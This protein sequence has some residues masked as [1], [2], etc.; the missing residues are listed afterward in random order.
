MIKFSAFAD[1]ADRSLQGQI[2]ALKENG[3]SLIELRSCDGINV[4]DFTLEYAKQV[5]EELDKNGIKVW[6]LGSPIG[7]VDITC[8]FDE[9]LEKFDNVLK[10]AKILGADKMRAFTFFKAYDSKDEV[11]KKMQILAD[12]ANEQGVLMCLENEKDVYGDI[13]SRALE[14]YNGVKGV[15][16][17]YDPANY[18]QCGI[19]AKDALNETFSATEYFHIKDVIAES[20]QIVPAGYGDGDISGMIE[21][22]GN[23]DAVLT[24]EPHLMMFDGYG[25]ID[26]TELKNKFTF[27]NNRESF[28]FAVKS[29]TEL[30]E[31]AGYK[32][33]NGGFELWK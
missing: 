1:E 4:G 30:L 28:A 12:K 17:V 22:I 18:I 7:K 16:L 8:D 26:D 9:Y 13:P 31:K 15:K 33:Q 11:I 24:L 25:A 20:G 5:R 32:K 10:V 27:S 19:S 6:S 23:Q 14:V 21:K 2:E 3:I 29:L